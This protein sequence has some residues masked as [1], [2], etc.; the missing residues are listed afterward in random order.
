VGAGD[1]QVTLPRGREGGRGLAG[2]QES[3]LLLLQEVTSPPEVC[4]SQ[5]QVTRGHPKADE[6]I[7]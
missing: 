2:P 4:P 3:Q 7:S 6:G 1:I 5:S